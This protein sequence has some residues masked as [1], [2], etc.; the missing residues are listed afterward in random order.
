MKRFFGISNIHIESDLLGAARSL[1]QNNAGIACI[2]GTG[3]NSCYYDG[4]NIIHNI[5]PLGYI[6]GDEGSGAVLGKNLLSGILKNQLTKDLQ[7][8][9]FQ[10]Y[11]TD[12]SSILENV[13]RKPFPNRYLAQYAYFISKHIRHE[14]ISNL[15]EFEFHLFFKKNVMQYKEANSLPLHFTGSIAYIFSSQLKNIALKN[16]F[17]IDT[18]TQTP[19]EGLVQYHQNNLSE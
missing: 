8:D 15:V 13:Y 7:K 4:K 11:Q 19:M 2:L 16:G 9:F 6:L 1:C 3:S 10:T 14:E 18:I 5:S 12:L 17:K